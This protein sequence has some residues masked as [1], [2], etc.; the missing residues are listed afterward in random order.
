MGT[1]LRLLDL[2]PTPPVFLFLSDSGLVDLD[3]I[4]LSSIGK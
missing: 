2:G 4:F 1:G 3:D